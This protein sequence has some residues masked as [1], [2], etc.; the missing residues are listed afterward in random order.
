MHK[1]TEI[2]PFLLISYTDPSQ[3][4]GKGHVTGELF[5]LRKY[6]QNNQPSAKIEKASKSVRETLGSQN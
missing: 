6:K 3:R 5:D 2:M 1:P 4:D